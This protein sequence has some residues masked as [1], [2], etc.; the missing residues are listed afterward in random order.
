MTNSAGSFHED[1]NSYPV[2]VDNGHASA[3]AALPGS[4]GSAPFALNSGS[5]VVPEF[6][7]YNNDVGDAHRNVAFFPIGTGGGQVHS[8]ILI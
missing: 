2:A 3:N 8:G 7:R 4:G 5:A 6:I 1:T